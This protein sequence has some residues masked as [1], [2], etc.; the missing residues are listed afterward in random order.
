[1]AYIKKAEQE[2]IFVKYILSIGIKNFCETDERGHTYYQIILK[3]GQYRYWTDFSDESYKKI[4]SSIKF[5]ENN[6]PSGLE[7]LLEWQ[8]KKALTNEPLRHMWQGTPRQE[9]N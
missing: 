4:K 9:I 3:D 7:Q 2:K 5:E 8:R 6:E 1:M